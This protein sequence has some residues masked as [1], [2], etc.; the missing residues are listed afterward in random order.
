[1]V[2]LNRSHIQGT[3]IYIPKKNNLTPSLKHDCLSGWLA[4]GHLEWL[5][6]KMQ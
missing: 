4:Q 3:G 2:Q 1:M 5:L 6:I